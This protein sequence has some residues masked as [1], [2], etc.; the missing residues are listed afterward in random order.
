MFTLEVSKETK[1][2]AL[3]IMDTVNLRRKALGLGDS[4]MTDE[5]A[6]TEHCINVA[7]ELIALHGIDGFDAKAGDHNPPWPFMKRK[8]VSR[9]N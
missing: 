6:V 1:D 2:K 9:E 4:K 8:R 3:A 7:S 5:R